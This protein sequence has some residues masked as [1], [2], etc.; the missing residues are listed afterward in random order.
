MCQS[1]SVGSDEQAGEVNRGELQKVHEDLCRK[2]ASGHSSC[3]FPGTATLGLSQDQT[4][5]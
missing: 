1:Q 3:S 5:M 4:R 2:E